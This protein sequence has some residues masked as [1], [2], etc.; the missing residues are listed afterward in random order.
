MLVADLM[1]RDPITISMD[2][3]VAQIQHLLEQHHFHHLLVVEEGRLVGVVSDRDVLAALSP[4]VGRRDERAADARL[5]KR[6]AHQI[7]TRD[8][9]RV[10]ASHPLIDAASLILA[11]RISAV[12]V[13][14]DADAPVGILTWRDLVSW[15]VGQMARNKAA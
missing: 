9:I 4:F 1:T 7:M 5:L 8:P 2:E 13:V 14:D 10:T 3:T 6:H 15:S 11:H 12:P